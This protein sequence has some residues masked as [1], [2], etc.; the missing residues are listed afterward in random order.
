MSACMLG[1]SAAASTEPAAPNVEFLGAPYLVTDA[2]AGPPAEAEIQLQA[3]GDVRGVRLNLPDF[4]DGTWYTSPELMSDYDFRLDTT[5]GSLNS[6]GTQAAD[7]WING[8]ANM[9]WGVRENGSGITAF[10]GTLRVRPAGGGADIS[11]AIVSL[12]AETV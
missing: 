11:T 6:P 12:S 1:A 7:T 4:D 10:N 8:F 9:Y 5:S 2:A 3:D